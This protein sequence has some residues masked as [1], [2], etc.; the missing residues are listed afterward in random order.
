MRIASGAVK[1]SSPVSA[2]HAGT[3]FDIGIA[4]PG[5]LSRVRQWV[6]PA[7]ERGIPLVRDPLWMWAG[8]TR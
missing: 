6:L 5:R 8:T 7:D 1:D 4:Y 2:I 3:R